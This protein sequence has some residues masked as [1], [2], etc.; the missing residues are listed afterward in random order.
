M[1]YRSFGRGTG[2][3]VSELAF[4]S[5]LFGTTWGYGTPPDEVR[6][7]LHTY[8]ERG[9]N[10]ID[11]ADFYQFGEAETLI[12]EFLD[13]QRNQVVLAS[14]YTLGA[15]S[16]PTVATTGNNRKNLIQSVEASLRRLRTGHID[17]LWVH[18]SDGL[19]DVEEI[20]R[21]LD[22]AVRAGK[23]LYVGFSDFP[24]WRIS[25]AATIAE[26]RGWT[27]V[28]AIQ[29]QY[30][31]VERASDREILPM[32]RAFDIGI[33][34]WSPLGGGLLTGK[35]RR[36]ESGRATT[37]GRVIH[38]ESTAQKKLV[39]DVVLEVAGETGQS[40]SQ[41]ALAWLLAQGIVPIIGPRTAEQLMDNIE[42]C[43]VRLSAEQIRKLDEASALQPEF[44]AD[45]LADPFQSDRLAGG[46]PAKLY[47][48]TSKPVR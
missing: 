8:A 43:S 13:G 35:Y 30:S 32:A 19:T 26:I 15:S 1:R 17:L 10:F 22:D 33:T 2:L 38:H 34:A 24:A 41:I 27:R 36:G 6:R 5:G 39:M 45:F 40:A 7:M 16:S 44:P 29:T 20:M 18:M 48:A 12:G 46:D 37:F 3:R 21:G 47:E 4:G 42:A 11:T 14:K 31:L 28:A 9:G 25:R 23:V